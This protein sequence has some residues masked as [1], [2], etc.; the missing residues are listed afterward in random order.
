MLAL[1]FA[2]AVVAIAVHPVAGHDDV[3]DAEL[4]DDEFEEGDEESDE[5]SESGEEGGEEE[6]GEESGERGSCQYI[7]RWRGTIR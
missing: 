3:D 1:L 2:A 4:G 5:E 6:S 7:R